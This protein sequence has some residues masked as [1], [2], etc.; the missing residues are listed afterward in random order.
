MGSVGQRT[1]KRADL[2]GGKVRFR[3]AVDARGFTV[4][5]NV[6][7]EDARLSASARLTLLLLRKH[8]WQDPSTFVT[9][10][11][12]AAE[13]GV[14]DRQV[15]RYLTELEESD[16][17]TV[18]RRLST[19]ESNI[20]WLEDL[21]ER[22]G[23]QA[24]EGGRTDMTTPQDRYVHPGRT[25]VSDNKDTATKTHLQTPPPVVGE[26]SEETVGEKPPTPPKGAANRE[27]ADEVSED[28]Q[29]L[30]LRIRSKLAQRGRSKEGIDYALDRLEVAGKV[31]APAAWCDKIA[32][33][34][35]ADREAVQQ[36]SLDQLAKDE[37]E[38]QRAEALKTRT[39]KH[40]VLHGEVEASEVCEL[41]SEAVELER[42]KTLKHLR[43]MRAKLGERSA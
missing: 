41:C 37:A 38:S 7:L 27:L 1:P 25:R 15:R 4:I 21:E 28:L 36:Q 19:G 33:R 9:Q 32:A 11:R 35:D 29:V 13:L 31:T 18:Q 43:D 12:L 42:A 26:R 8:A 24:V 40:G 5:Q 23:L 34:F 6:I 16:L 22:Y 30:A 2:D 14:S 20:Y 39:C 10:G 17:I 3:S